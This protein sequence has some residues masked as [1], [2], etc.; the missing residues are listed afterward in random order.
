MPEFF[1]KIKN[2]KT[3]PTY[4]YFCDGEWLSSK[5]GK[6]VEIFSPVTDELL[7]RVQSLTKEEID[8]AVE[9]AFWAQI[10]W[11]K[12][13]I[14]K[15][16]RILHLA[17]DWLREHKDYLTNLLV[18]EIG[19]TISEAEDEVVRTAD[20]IDYFAEEGRGLRG[21]TLE[22]D[23][24]PGYEKG[25][26]A[27][28]NR[29]P[30]G[31]I[32]SISP[33]NYPINLSASK[34]A[35]ALITGNAVIVKPAT[36]GCLA[37]LH[38]VEILRL[39]GLPP[40]VLNTVTGT[41]SEIGDYLVTNSKISMI[42]FT[43]STLV[44]EKLAKKAGMI[45]LL[46]ECGGNNPAIV[47]DDA[48]FDLA[49]KEIVKG[50]FSYSGQRCTAVKYVLGLETV[51]DKLKARLARVTG[52]LV[53]MGDPREKSTKMVG[54]LINKE[55][56]EEVENR[57]IKAKV[58]GAEI[59]SGGKR[60]GLYIEPTI[61]DN[62]KPYWEIV[63]VETFGPV[64]S[65]IRVANINEAVKIVNS[66]FYGLQACL[67]TKDEGTGIRLAEKLNV[68]T[69]QINAKPQRGPDHFPFLGIK[70]SGIGVQGIRHT[71]EAMTRPK[72]V[73]L[74]KPE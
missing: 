53:K 31:V 70:G 34:I 4:K 54:P 1:E 29:V 39:A 6:T 33:F 45:P 2:D 42:C 71:L 51:I 19:K 52:E 8:E 64:L 15:R 65:L 38:L 23:S 24:F 73:V 22:S 5:S 26:L 11:Q 57:I 35:P 3:P 48:D 41:G 61:L 18:L 66:G 62:V 68:G 17:A 30:L 74:N 72:P 55:A 58:A 14:E 50:A 59:V 49:S 13:P 20:L 10:S 46:F 9:A 21:E 43:G 67:F 16:A 28:V 12:T 27:I 25:K 7:G 60:Q 44:G 47:L 36:Q 63:K 40:G 32:L 69:V 56:A 37:T